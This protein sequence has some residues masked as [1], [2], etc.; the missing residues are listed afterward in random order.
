MGRKLASILTGIG[1]IIFP[2]LLLVGCGSAGDTQAK[3]PG[4]S[5]VDIRG[6][7]TSISAMESASSGRLGSILIEGEFEQDTE[8]DKASV[9]VT[10][11]TRILRQID[12]DTE[13]AAFSDLRVGQRV[14]AIFTGAVAESYPVQAYAVEITILEP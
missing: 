14:Q 2:L 1:C 11:E 10:D 13:E 3:E 9:T 6:Y 4:R 8:F 12:G 7:I 5:G